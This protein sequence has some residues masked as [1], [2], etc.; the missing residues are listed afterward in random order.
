M[1]IP[2]IRYPQTALNGTSQPNERHKCK[3]PCTGKYGNYG[4]K[5]KLFGFWKSEN[6]RPY[7]VRRIKL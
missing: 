1:P 6:V 2:R 5:R 4:A 7:I 3:V